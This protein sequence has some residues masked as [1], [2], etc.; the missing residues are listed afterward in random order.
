MTPTVPQD[1]AA[2]PSVTVG[3]DG[4]VSSSEK[5]DDEWVTVE[6]PVELPVEPCRKLLKSLDAS[7]LVEETR[8]SLKN[9]SLQE[10][11][12]DAA[13][14]AAMD[15]FRVADD[16][17]TT[18]EKLDLSKLEKRLEIGERDKD[19]PVETSLV[20]R[21]VRMVQWNSTKVLTDIESNFPKLAPKVK[22]AAKGC[23]LKSYWPRLQC[24]M[25]KWLDDNVIRN[26][27]Q[28]CA[29]TL[30]AN[31][32]VVSIRVRTHG[33]GLC[34]E[35]KA[36]LY[37]RIHPMEVNLYTDT[38]F[39]VITSLYVKADEGSV[40]GVSFSVET[41]AVLKTVLSAGPKPKVQ[42]DDADSDEGNDDL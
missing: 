29:Y 14:N 37:P 13:W 16:S 31:S 21:F 11:F 4:A 1:K 6:S 33:E 26:L 5:S 2:S 23:L 7:A 27:A 40:E 12:S 38:V 32:E 17:L 19:T 34:I 8:K 39:T 20:E 22:K 35:H 28:G 25:T 41:K 3:Q 36:H 24:A 9:Q 30:R 18:D 15:V 10:A 42:I